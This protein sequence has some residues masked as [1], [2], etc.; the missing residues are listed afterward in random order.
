M[1][2][3]E[4]RLPLQLLRGLWQPEWKVRSLHSVWRNINWKIFTGKFLTRLKCPCTTSTPWCQ[5]KEPLSFRINI[6]LRRRGVKNKEFSYR[7]VVV[8][9]IL[10]ARPNPSTPRKAPNLRRKP[11]NWDLSVE[12]EEISFQCLDVSRNDE[13]LSLYI[14]R[15]VWLLFLYKYK[16]RREQLSGLAVSGVAPCWPVQLY[17][18]L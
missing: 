17:I 6:F 16:T 2:D 14:N 8:H 1:S 4:G 10:S 7:S 13:K 11:D 5:S 3:R 15:I 12:R 9:F 18:T